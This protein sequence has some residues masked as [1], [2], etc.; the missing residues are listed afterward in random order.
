MFRGQMGGDAVADADMSEK[1]KEAYKK[2]SSFSRSQ[3]KQEKDIGEKHIVAATAAATA[4]HNSKQAEY[5][6]QWDNMSQGFGAAGQGP[7]TDAGA[8]RRVLRRAGRA[9]GVR[10]QAGRGGVRGGDALATAKW[11]RWWKGR[12]KGTGHAKKHWK[13]DQQGIP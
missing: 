13:T 5:E 6:Q 1:L 7:H 11:R 12:G 4:K 8:A 2:D 9:G 10:G 3:T